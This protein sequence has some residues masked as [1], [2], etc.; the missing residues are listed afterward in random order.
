MANSSLCEK[1]KRCKKCKKGQRWTAP[2]LAEDEKVL[3]ASEGTMANRSLCEK[4]KRCKKCKKD[5]RWTAHCGRR[6][7][8][9]KSV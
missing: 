4:V 8:S 1:V 3:K 2:I 7:K 6:R 5:Q 9:V